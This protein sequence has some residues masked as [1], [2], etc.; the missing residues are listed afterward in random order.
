MLVE[1][2]LGTPLPF[3]GRQIKKRQ[4]IA[5]LVV[6]AVGTEGSKSFL[7]DEPG[8]RIGE[9]RTRVFVGR[10]TLGLEEQCPAGAK[11]LQDVVQ[12]SGNGDEL[13]LCRAVEVGTAVADVR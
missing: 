4:E 7:V 9:V 11:A 2:P 8:D 5:A 3:G 10:D 1:E 13:G 12:P 6:G